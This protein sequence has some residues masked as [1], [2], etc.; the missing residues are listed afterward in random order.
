M[1]KAVLFDLDGTLLP[2]DTDLFLQEYLKLLSQTTAPY[3]EPE[4]FVS[5]LMAATFK[6]IANRE[7]DKTN[8][9]VFIH[10]FFSATGLDPAIMMPVFEKFYQTDF[11]RLAEFFNPD[12]LVPT[13][14]ESTMG[15]YKVVIATNPVFP[16]IAIKERLR[17][18]GI[19][20]F[21]FALITAYENMHFC[22][23]HVEYYLEI[24]EKIEVKPEECLMV[25]ND[26]DEDLV[27]GKIGMQTFLVDTYLI[28][29]T[30][31][32]YV[33]N[34]QGSLKDFYTFITAEEK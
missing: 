5:E 9:A 20:S 8:E 29:R 30:N 18:L 3:I 24:A 10:E 26:V 31:R 25:G 19:D 28:N 15:K 4:H 16:E 12:P 23:P 7:P 21:A 6:M 33:T 32:D 13:I 1:I 17:W 34:Y 2:M 14:I 22:K 11:C 27:A